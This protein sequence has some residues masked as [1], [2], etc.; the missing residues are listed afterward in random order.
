MSLIELIDTQWDV[1]TVT[2]VTVAPNESELIDTQWDV[3]IE[4]TDENGVSMIE[5]IDTQWDV[6]NKVFPEWLEEFQN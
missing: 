4:L 2:S 5:L 3:N 6:N 1:N